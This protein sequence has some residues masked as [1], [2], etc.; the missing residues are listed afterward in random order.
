MQDMEQNNKN[1]FVI[2]KI[3]ER[4]VN[5][6]KLLRRTV[7]TAAMA[8]MFGLIACFTF[9][10]L[11]PVISNWLYPQEEPNIVIFP[12]EQEEMEPEEML[13]DNLL[14]EAT[15]EPTP[16]R[17]PVFPADSD[18]EQLQELLNYVTLD[19]E[20]YTQLYKALGDMVKELNHGMVTVTA[21]KSKTD[22]LDNVTQSETL[23]T[24]VVIGNNGKEL[25]IL[26][27]YNFLTNADSLKVTFWE[28]YTTDCQLKQKHEETDIAILSI[29]TATLGSKLQDIT[30]ASFGSTSTQQLLCTPVIALGS[31]MGVSGSVGY[32][33]VTSENSQVSMVDGNYELLITD[34][35]GSQ[36]ANGFLFNMRGQVIGMIT[37]KKTPVDM[38][39]MIAAYGIS[40]LK[41]LI[42]NM[43]G[44][45]SVAYLGITGSDV[46]EEANTEG[47]VPKGVYIKDIEMNSP[48]MEAGILPGDIMVGIDNTVVNQFNDYFQAI[49]NAKGGDTVKIRVMRQF[50]QEYIL[51][52]FSIILGN[53]E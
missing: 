14:A 33:M 9:L 45:N 3:K 38:R 6:R 42:S 34:I 27:N 35:Y 44:G 15:P 5:R 52:E 40:D 41:K 13:S 32:G 28:G 19:V 37:T 51:M 24:G 29:D 30:I 47:Q 18:Q 7:I 23:G 26:T 31:P 39:N 21:I 46:S 20:N 25:L 43:S 2:E 11:E 22:W 53:A 10:V 36:N 12:E 17:M 48:A 49:T 1:D 8:V 4:P 16:T 50:Q